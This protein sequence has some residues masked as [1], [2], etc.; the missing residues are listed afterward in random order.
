MK[1]ELT[2]AYLHSV[3]DYDEYTGEFRWAQDDRSHGRERGDIAGKENAKGG[4]FINLCGGTHAAHKLAWLWYYGA[5]VPKRITHINK[6]PYDNRINNL[7][8]SGYDW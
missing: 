2:Q 1:K 8:A 5:P 4:V 6:I 7:D 3:L